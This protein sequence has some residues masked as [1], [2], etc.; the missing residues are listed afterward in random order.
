MKVLVRIAAVVAVLALIT[1]VGLKITVQ[2]IKYRVH[3]ETTHWDQH[4][5]EAFL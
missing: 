4:F 1:G 5:R 3:Q 2:I